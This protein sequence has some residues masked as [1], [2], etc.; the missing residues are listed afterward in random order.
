MLYLLHS[1]YSFLPSNLS[2]LPRLTKWSSSLNPP[3]IVVHFSFGGSG[4]G[5]QWV[6]ILDSSSW[7][8]N[9]RQRSSGASSSS[10][11]TLNTCHSSRGE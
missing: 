8:R 5:I 4:S 3:S 10:N 7:N 6:T 1:C 9:A 2:K 11:P